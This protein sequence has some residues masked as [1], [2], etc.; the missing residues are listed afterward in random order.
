MG[1]PRVVE[2]AT[3]TQ[4]QRPSTSRSFKS[5]QHALESSLSLQVVAES[6]LLALQLVPVDI[7]RCSAAAVFFRFGYIGV[8]L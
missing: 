3:K 6:F 4:I 5:T 7:I 8:A 1:Y 2:W